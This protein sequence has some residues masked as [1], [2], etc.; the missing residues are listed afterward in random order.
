MD[1]VPVS[2][3]NSFE[4]MRN[5]NGICFWWASDLMKRMGYKDMNS[6][7][8]VMNRATNALISLGIDHHENIIPQ[9]RTDKDGKQI[10]DYKLTRFACYLVAMNGDPKKPEVGPMQAYFAEQT[11]Q[12]EV[13]V[14]GAED[15]DRLLIR[16]ELKT[17]QVALAG[18]AASAGV[19]DFLRFQ[20]AGYRGMYNMPV[21]QLQEMRK[22]KGKALQDFMGK[23]E[24]AANLFRVT[25][26]EEK[27]K[28]QGIRG[29]LQAEV[30][31]NQVA[32]QVRKIVIENTGKGPEALP[33]VEKIS[34]V[35]K[36]LKTVGR[37]LNK[38][39]TKGKK[40]MKVL[41]NSSRES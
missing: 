26:T 38:L 11:R 20:D 21:Y 23:T 13:M 16:Q 32:K 30:A 41:P 31:H 17:G 34:E 37:S 36:R 29:Q 2:P 10:R 1:L 28:S 18:V 33:V 40:K 15:M 6:F 27:L 39:D 25:Q 35:A 24:L 12:L 3:A 19:N 5:E 8:N 4:E 14:A 9:T 7:Q 22:L